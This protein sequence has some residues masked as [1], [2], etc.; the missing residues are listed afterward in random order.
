MSSELTSPHDQVEAR[1]KPSRVTWS[2]YFALGLS[3]AAA[4]G[5]FSLE[6]GESNSAITVDLIAGTRGRDNYIAGLV[7]GLLVLSP[8]ILILVTIGIGFL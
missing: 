7:G 4:L 3:L 2:G 6:M 5:L 8:F 1:T